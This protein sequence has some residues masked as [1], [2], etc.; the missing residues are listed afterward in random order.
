MFSARQWQR[1]DKCRQEGMKSKSFMDGGFILSPAGRFSFS[2]RSLLLARH[3]CHLS[4]AA[5]LTNLISDWPEVSLWKKKNLFA[6]PQKPRG[7]DR[8]TL[9]FL[10]V[11][12]HNKCR[13]KSPNSRVHSHAVEDF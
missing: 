1:S 2:S 3:L 7:K 6:V 13:L 9:S 10:F 5:V 11:Q 8:I 4:F 12:V